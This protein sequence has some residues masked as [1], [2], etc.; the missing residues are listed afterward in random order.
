[1]IYTINILLILVISLSNLSIINVLED[2][3]SN[4]YEKTELQSDFKYFRKKLETSHP[5]LYLYTSKKDFD[6]LLD[7]IYDSIGNNTQIEFFNKI[8]RLNSSIK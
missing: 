1:M 7:S 6:A 4:K 3:C 2:P 5:N 8:C